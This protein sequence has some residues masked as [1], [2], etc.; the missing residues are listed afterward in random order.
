MSPG[1]YSAG[2]ATVAGVAGFLAAGAS[3]ARP[4]GTPLPAREPPSYIFSHYLTKLPCVEMPPPSIRLQLILL[5]LAMF[6]LIRGGAQ[7]LQEEPAAVRPRADL[8][9]RLGCTLIQRTSA[10]RI[11]A[12][13]AGKYAARKPPRSPSSAHISRKAR[14]PCER[15]RPPPARSWWLACR[16]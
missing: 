1:V 9:E 16:S 11:R 2:V 8:V 14:S 6:G 3:T 13:R 15:G 10:G 12:R 5:Q 7:R 4:P